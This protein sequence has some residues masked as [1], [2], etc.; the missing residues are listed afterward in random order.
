M[1]ADEI[2][3]R[4]SEVV[5]IHLDLLDAILAESLSV[6]QA[7][8]ASISLRLLFD[9]SLN[10]LASELGHALIIPAPD[11]REVPY[12]EAMIFACGGYTLA[13]NPI[14]PY[15][16]YR[17]PGTN[18]PYRTQFERQV[19][20][21][22]KQYAPQDLRLGQFQAQPCL[23]M[24][25]RGYSREAIVRY[26]ANKCG[27]AHHDDDLRKFSEIEHGITQVGHGLEETGS[28]L[29]V[30]FLEVLGTAWFLAAAP[31]VRALRA[32]LDG[33]A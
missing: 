2:L 23:A 24:L 16:L 33:S 12:D 31:D 5:A 10:R 27:G 14:A 17:E 29:S 4:R 18:S 9:G 32:R 19:A 13:D 28:G 22:P 15:Y 30:V 21:S 20:A 8:R 3:I 25:G 7:I 11:L 6:S 1:K 26:V